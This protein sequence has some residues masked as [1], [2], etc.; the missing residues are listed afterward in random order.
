M[1]AAE[2]DEEARALQVLSQGRKRVK[3][4]EEELDS[5]NVEL[6]SKN[7][8]LES[9]KRRVEELELQLSQEQ[10]EKER[11]QTVESDM[12]SVVKKL[13]VQHEEG[14]AS[15][16]K[17]VAAMDVGIREMEEVLTHMKQMRDAFKETGEML[18]Q[19]SM[20]AVARRVAYKVATTQR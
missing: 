19:N 6:D 10:K 11:L 15:T 17:L 12:L 13:T 16:Q 2:E 20:E 18:A 3:K 8:E 14:V 5:K 9:K 1:A 4:L 7:V